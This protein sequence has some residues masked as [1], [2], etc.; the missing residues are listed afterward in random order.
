MK[1]NTSPVINENNDSINGDIQYKPLNKIIEC[2]QNEIVHMNISGGE[3]AF[4]DWQGIG[5]L[6]SYCATWDTDKH[7]EAQYKR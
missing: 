5:P 1:V 7:A 6:F 3:Y 2:S 4:P